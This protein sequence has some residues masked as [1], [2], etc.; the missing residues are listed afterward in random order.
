MKFSA[1]DFYLLSPAI[2]LMVLALVVMAVDMFVK[3]RS[4]VAAISL[5]GLIV[6]AGF[7]ISQAM[8][9]TG[10]HKAFWD[11]LII[12]QYSIFF[13]ILFL[14]IAA[15]MILA[16]YNYVERYVKGQGE[17]YVLMLFSVVG[18]MLMASTSELITVYISLEL[19]SFPL[20]VMA[21]LIRENDKSAEAA[22]KY[23]LLGAMSSAILL[24]GFALLYGLTGT[25]D[26]AGIAKSFGQI[27]QGN[28]AVLVADILIIAGFGFKISAVPFHMWA[29]DIYE[30]SP[31]PATAFFSVGSKAAGFAAMIRVFMLGNLGAVNLGDLVVVLSIVAVLTMTVGN[32]VAAVQS[33][34][35]RMMAYSGIAQAGYI[36]VGF[37]A[38]LASG[39]PQ[40]NSAVLFYLLVY[41]VTNLGAFAGI[42]GLANLTGGDR[43]EDFRGLFYRAPL[44]SIGTALC[45]LSL[46]GIPPM[47]GF[48]SKLYLFSAA[49]N[50]G[51]Y[52]LVVVALLNSV[53][54]LVYYGRIVKAMFFDK[55]AKQGRLS[56][57]FSL[58]T[59]LVLMSAA[60]VVMT[61]VAQVFLSATS[62][63]AGLLMAGH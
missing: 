19:T 10:T 22:V 57:S 37:I 56:T 63:P 29:P 49:W 13:T 58:G 36:L 9:L 11:M 52:W 30:G 54:S 2:S 55:P 51:Q 16:S 62:L 28:L 45:L 48:I 18:M 1:F 3:R 61:L 6:P 53:I 59:S 15:V 41:A 4:V 31:T 33:N 39:Q 44:L 35:K 60:L 34:A 32:V 25:T 42:I 8:T 12:D 7:A 14:V 5:V 26:L 24:Y 47:A 43:I 17:F 23:V 46:G 21:G 40:G 27:G 38:S 50:M 20:Y